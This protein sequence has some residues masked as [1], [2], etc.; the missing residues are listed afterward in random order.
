M[1]NAIATALIL[2]GYAA[3]QGAFSFPSLTCDGCKSTLHTLDTVSLNNSA[4]ALIGLCEGSGVYPDVC[5]GI[6]DDLLPSLKYALSKASIINATASNN[7]TDADWICPI[8]AGQC[9]FPNTTLPNVMTISSASNPRTAL[10]STVNTADTYTV[11]HLSDLH[12]DPD[13]QAGTAAV[14]AYPMCCRQGTNV[15]P[16][17]MTGVTPRNAS[18]WGDYNCDVSQKLAENLL[19]SIASVVQ[20]NLNKTID[21]SICRRFELMLPLFIVQII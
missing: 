12:I 13:Y 17:N 14:C 9:D 11:L 10:A 8:I 15:L 19:S 18:T 7:V 1:A 6:A 20:T 21:F 3:A 16:T 4:T 2:A 5:Q